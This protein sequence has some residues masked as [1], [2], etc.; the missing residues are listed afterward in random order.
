MNLLG[1]ILD[2]VEI[3]ATPAI[4]EGCVKGIEKEGKAEFKVFGKE[5]TLSLNKPTEKPSETRPPEN[6][7]T[8]PKTSST[9][10]CTDGKKRAP[11][12]KPMITF[13]TPY[14]TRDVLTTT[15]RTC[16]GNMYTQ[17]CFHYRSVI[18]KHPEYGLMTC[19]YSKAL[20]APRPQV[21]VYSNQ[22][23]GGWRTG[24]M[25]QPGLSCERDEFPPADIWQDRGGPVWIRLNPKSDNGRAGPALFGGCGNPPRSSTESERSVRQW[26]HGNKITEEWARTLVITRMVLSLE[27]ANMQPWADDGLTQNPCY[28]LTLVNDPG[29]ALLWEDEWYDDQP[30]AVHRFAINSYGKPPAFQ[31]T[32]GKQSREGYWRRRNLDG[33][34]FNPSEIVFNDGNSTRKATDEEL[35]EHFNFIRCTDETCASEREALGI[36]SAVIV[37]TPRATPIE[38]AVITTVAAA[39]TTMQTISQAMR[40]V[41]ADLPQITE[42]P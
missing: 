17:A 5:K 35:F 6:S 14:V 40:M 12:L 21:L 3:A 41:S 9:Q 33:D 13:S 32:Q 30:L 18:R 16:S 27:F 29:Y 8:S 39:P 37:A 15:T 23:D 24:W 42:N 2:L 22:H 7:H 20:R 11:C 38:V 4:I 19:P 36:E 28:P 31:V 25:Q 1:E 10:S 26:K 34:H